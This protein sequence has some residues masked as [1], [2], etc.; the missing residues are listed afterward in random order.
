MEATG[1]SVRGD[2]GGVGHFEGMAVCW[3]PRRGI[4]PGPC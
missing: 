1:R 4:L 3:C 2:V